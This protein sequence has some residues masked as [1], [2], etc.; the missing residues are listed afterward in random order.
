[1][2]KS[3]SLAVRVAWHSSVTQ[4]S[5]LLKAMVLGTPL[6]HCS[7]GGSYLGGCVRD[8]RGGRTWKVQDTLLPEASTM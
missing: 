8:G 5:S 2:C 4:N 3:R 6:P 1:M 7:S